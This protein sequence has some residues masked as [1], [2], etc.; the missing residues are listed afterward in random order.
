VYEYPAHG[1]FPSPSGGWEYPYDMFLQPRPTDFGSNYG[2]SNECDATGR[3]IDLP[4][5]P[6]GSSAPLRA[7]DPTQPIDP[8]VTTGVEPTTST[9][10]PTTLPPP[11]NHLREYAFAEADR[12]FLVRIVT[13]DDAG[14][15][16][17]TQAFEIVN[18]LHVELPS[19]TTTTVDVGPPDKE[20]ARQEI[21]DAFRAAFGASSPVA[22]ADSVEGGHPLATEEQKKEA[23][24]IAGNADELSRK[25]VEASERG[26][27]DIR[28]NWIEW[29]SPTRA[30]VNFDLLVDGQPGTANTTG[31]AVVE[32]GHWRMGRGTYCEITARGGVQCPT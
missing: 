26:G 19:V 4:I 14:D 23:K 9:V 16:L 31:Y 32:D 27:L 24:E 21:L 17:L 15:D 1:P 5:L 2:T 10:A 28:I 3:P 30:T 6:D 13:V 20:S 29:D 22:F 11:V 7:V 8:T 18:S 12:A 25:A